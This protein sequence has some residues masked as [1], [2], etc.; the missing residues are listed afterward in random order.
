MS[1]ILITIDGKDYL[2]RTRD[3]LVLE[4]AKEDGIYIPTLCHYEGIKPKDPAGFV[5]V[6]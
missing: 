2:C 1:K 3:K 6:R 5:P 4:A